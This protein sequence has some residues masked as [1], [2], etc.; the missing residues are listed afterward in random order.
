EST[1]YEAFLQ[2]VDREIKEK[3]NVADIYTVGLKVYTTPDTSVQDHVEFFLT[4]SDDNSIPYPD[5]EMQAGVIYLD[6]TTGA[7]IAI[8]GRRNSECVDEYNF[9]IQ[10]GQQPVSTFKPIVAYAP[11]IEYNK[12]STYHQIN[13]DKPYEVG[14]TNPIRNWNRQYQGW[15]SARYAL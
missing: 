3:V 11:A 10:G 7:I 8:G 9:A 6:T 13:D 4:Y 5:S 1:E 2:Q 12:W 15:M 14:G